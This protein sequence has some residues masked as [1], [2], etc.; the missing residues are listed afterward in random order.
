MKWLFAFSLF[1]TQASSMA[2]KV[3]ALF[4]YLIAV[5]VFFSVLIFALVVFFAIRYRRRSDQDRPKEIHGNLMLELVWSFIPLA[6][7]V[8]MFFWGAKLFFQESVPPQNASELFVVAKRW[9]WKIQHPEGPREI[10]ELHLPLDQAVKLTMTSEDVIHSFYVPDF[11]VKMDVLPG[12]YTRLWFEPNRVGTYHL[13]CAE[14]C[15]TKHSEMRGTIVVM[16]PA[17]YQQWLDKMKATEKPMASRGED[18]FTKN[19]CVS[20]HGD[21]PSRRGPTLENLF[22]S[23]VKLNNGS[24]VMADENYI[25]ESIL[26]PEA[27]M[28]DGYNPLMPTFK[29]LLTE[30]ELVDILTYIKSLG[31]INKHE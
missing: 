19:R 10:N 22:N 29:G 11:R 25:R 24:Y 30:E 9:M 7:T 6:L 27:K 14:Y 31:E 26:N 1:P 21:V 8:V 20:C 23:S 5:A 3:D 13:F 17:D 16:Q 18:L 15:G 28:V 2:G 4:F 12:R